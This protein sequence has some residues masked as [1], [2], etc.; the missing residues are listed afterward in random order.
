MLPL[1][2]IAIVGTLGYG[3][4]RYFNPQAAQ[5]AANSATDIVSETMQ[6]ITDLF[7]KAAPYKDAIQGAQDKYGIPEN[8]LAKLLNAESSYNPAIISGQRKSTTGATGIAQFM[9]GTAAELGVNPTDPMS[10]IDGAGR[11]LKQ[12]YDQFGNWTEAIAAYNWG[13]G[14]VSKKGLAKAPTE[15][16]NYVQKIAG[17]DIRQ[18]GG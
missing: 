16:V 17:V 9:P 1:I 18:T 15:T 11:Y 7:P 2:P 13:P 3:L 6:S 8:Y 10:S 14:N 4:W 5:D 12:L